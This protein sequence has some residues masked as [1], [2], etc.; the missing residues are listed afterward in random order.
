[1]RT[2]GLLWLGLALAV[3]SVGAESPRFIPR[4]TTVELQPTSGDGRLVLR[5][6]GS[7]MR[8]R[9]ERGLG[10]VLVVQAGGI[11]TGAPGV[12]PGE[13]AWIEQSIQFGHQE[14]S[15]L[16]AEATVQP[17]GNQLPYPVGVQQTWE[18]IAL[19]EVPW[20]EQ[21]G[22]GPSPRDVGFAGFQRAGSDLALVVQGESGEVLTLR[23]YDEAYR[24]PWADWRY[25]GQVMLPAS[26]IATMV[27]PTRAER[28]YFKVSNWGA[29]WP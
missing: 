4:D 16:T 13:V 25:V 27:V 7:S 10:K 17:P 1:M 12:A 26:G 28:A 14:V 6:N 18:L 2:I 3:R 22:P 9:L 20:N 8:L 15:I 19:E 23:Q 24:L 5:W 11:L 21:P 29:G